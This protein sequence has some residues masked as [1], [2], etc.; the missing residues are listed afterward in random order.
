MVNES[1]DIQQPHSSLPVPLYKD[2]YFCDIMM[3]MGSHDVTES[4]GSNV[5]RRQELNSRRG[6]MRNCA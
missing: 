3:I 4:T 5:G 1:L 6:R 2:S